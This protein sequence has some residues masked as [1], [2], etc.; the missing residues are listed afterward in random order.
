METK[1][2]SLV[3]DGECPLCVAYS[4]AFVQQGMLSQEGRIFYQHLQDTDS[5]NID[6][7]RARNEIALVMPDGS[8]RYGVDS[9]LTLLQPRYPILGTLMKVGFLKILARALYRFISANRKVFAPGRP[10]ND[11]C[12]PDFYLTPR[13]IWL[14]LGS[15]FSGF[16]LFAFAATLPEQLRSGS[17][18]RELGIC[19]GQLLFQSIALYQLPFQKK[20][21]YLGNMVTVSFLGSLLLWPCIL[22]FRMG[23]LVNPWFFMGGFMAIVLAM[24]LEHSRRMHRLGL[25]IYPSV[26]WLSYRLFILLFLSF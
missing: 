21:D 14:L 15:L 2:C 7:N 22:F 23:W 8:V 19:F 12:K 4:Q 16:S 6:L 3:V 13:L 1:S 26:T 9:L 18:L 11:V 17:L 20:M 24:L 5:G 10:G 25:G